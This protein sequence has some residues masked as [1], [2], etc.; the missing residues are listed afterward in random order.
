L[1]G[2]D[3]EIYETFLRKGNRGTRRAAGS[4]ELGID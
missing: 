2:T 3:K 1:A 4:L